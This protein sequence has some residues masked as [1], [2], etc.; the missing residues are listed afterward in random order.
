MV[1]WRSPISGKVKVSGGVTDAHAACG[2]GFDWSVDKGAVTLA[3]G[4][5]AQRWRPN[6]SRQPLGLRALT[7]SLSVQAI[8]CTSSFGPGP[9][10]DHT[11]DSTRLDVTITSESNTSDLPYSVRDLLVAA[12]ALQNTPAPGGP[13]SD[14]FPLVPGEVAEVASLCASGRRELTGRGQRPPDSAGGRRFESS[15]AHPG[16]SWQFGDDPRR[17]LETS[18]GV[19]S[20]RDLRGLDA[21]IALVQEARSPEPGVAARGAAGRP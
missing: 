15:C 9:S 19:T 14:V 21:D 12:R 6:R 13:V 16:G 18:R 3:S 4:V 17:Q 1:G 2:D 7:A 5:V 11:C 20:R 10:G 8:F